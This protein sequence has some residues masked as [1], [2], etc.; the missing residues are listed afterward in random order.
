MVCNNNQRNIENQII[1]LDKPIFSCKI[2][3]ETAYMDIK[4]LVSFNGNFGT[5]ITS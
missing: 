2:T 5:S 3:N 4:I 1:K